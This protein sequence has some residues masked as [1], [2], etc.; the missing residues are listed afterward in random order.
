MERRGQQI[1][2]FQGRN[3]S[4]T[5]GYETVAHELKEIR[6]QFKTYARLETLMN[7]VMKQASKK[8]TEDNSRTRQPE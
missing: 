1:S 3:T 2:N 7:R 6:Y 8:H 4:N 5:G